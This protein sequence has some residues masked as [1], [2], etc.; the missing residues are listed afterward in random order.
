MIKLILFILI[1]VVATVIVIVRKFSTVASGQ[2]QAFLIN[3]IKRN[4]ARAREYSRMLDIPMDKKPNIN[5][6]AF[7]LIKAKIQSSDSIENYRI[8]HTTPVDNQL[9]LFTETVFTDFDVTFTGEA[10]DVEKKSYHNFLL[11]HQ[12]EANELIIYSTMYADLNEKTQKQGFLEALMKTM[13]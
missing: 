9:L 8:L 6:A 1:A 5:L 4:P 13:V 7:E 11:S 2:S 10:G 12:P 3:K